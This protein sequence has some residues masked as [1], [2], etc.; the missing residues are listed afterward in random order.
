MS[1]RSIDIREPK[2][3]GASRKFGDVFADLSNELSH[4][5][6]DELQDAK[7]ELRANAPT[8]GRAAQL[9]FAATV[10]G[11]LAVLFVSLAAAIGLAELIPTG[12]AFL[13]VGV[14]FA[15]GAALLYQ[16]RQNEL[17]PPLDPVDGN[18]Y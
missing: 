18:D 8:T 2:P 6:H 11:M 9:A 4:L 15:A 14:V 3:G 16:R 5:V 1:D 7:D 12:F 10:A 17:S 13:L